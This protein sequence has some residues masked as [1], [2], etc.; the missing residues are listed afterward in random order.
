MMASMS[1]HILSENSCESLHYKRPFSAHQDSGLGFH[2]AP[3]GA[4]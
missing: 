4:F 3:V 2:N 1:T